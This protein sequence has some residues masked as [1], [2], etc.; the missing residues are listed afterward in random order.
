[1]VS[2]EHLSAA[3]D[4]PSGRHRDASATDRQRR[5]PTMRALVSLPVLVAFGLF[6]S[7]ARAFPAASMQLFRVD[8]NGVKPLPAVGA[9]LEGVTAGSAARP[10]AKSSVDAA[11]APAAPQNASPDPTA[12][13]IPSATT[14]PAEAGLWTTS[15]SLAPATGMAQPQGLELAQSSGVP[16]S[17]TLLRQS[18]IGPLP[19]NLSGNIR[20]V[21]ISEDGTL[22]Q[23][24]E[25]IPFS[26][27]RVRFSP[28]R[29]ELSVRPTAP[30][31]PGQSVMLQLPSRS[32]S[33]VR[34]AYPNHLAS[35]P[36]IFKAP[37]VS[38][39]PT[40]PPPPPGGSTPVWLV[41]AGALVFA[42]GIT[43]AFTAG[44]GGGGTN[45]SSQ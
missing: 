21:A 25:E 34:F 14:S 1:M 18:F 13:S 44:G 19:R 39:L 8:G 33:G 31:P 37:A 22:G 6:T 42:V 11:A 15:V 28:D 27:P 7:P 36:C 26:S 41:V 16:S 10:S 24:V 45:P 32:P 29:T 20:L 5:L 43:A 38:S 35:T 23:I 4:L 40:T 3:G 9:L 30:I 12:V 2:L 17:L